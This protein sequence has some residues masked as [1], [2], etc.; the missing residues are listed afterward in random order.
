MEKKLKVVEKMSELRQ[1]VYALLR[2]VG[3]EK[4]RCETWEC[5]EYGK[6]PNNFK[7]E[8]LFYIYGEILQ[9][10]HIIKVGKKE[11][12]LNGLVAEREKID[13][14]IAAALRNEKDK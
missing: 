9:T 3:V 1:E 2:E 12:D 7:D 5:D 14:R 10:I 8:E 11:R 6:D 4:F 13:K